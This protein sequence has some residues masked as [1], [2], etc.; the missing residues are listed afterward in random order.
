[1]PELTE[2]I[3]RLHHSGRTVVM[4]EHHMDVVLGLAGRVAVMHHGELLAFDGP[5]AVMADPVVQA[6][7]LGEPL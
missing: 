6:A 4:V 7:Y 5:D 2:L 3:R 1:M